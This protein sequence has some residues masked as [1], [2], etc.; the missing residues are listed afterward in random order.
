MM[1]DKITK[2][3][4]ELV[5]TVA[6]LRSPGGCPW[7][8]EQTHDSLKKYAIEETY[9]VIEAIESGDPK[10]IEDELGDLL[11][12]VLLHAQ[13]ASESEQFDI[14]DVCRVIRE[15]LQRRHPHVFADVEISGVE[16]VLYNWEQIKKGEPGYDQRKSVLDGVPKSLP[17]LMR[18]AEISKKAARTGFDWPDVDSIL[19]KLREETRELEEAINRGISKEIENEIGDLLFTTVNIAR[20][21]GIDP[22]EALRRM[23]EKFTRRFNHIEESAQRSGKSIQDMTLEEMDRVWD[24]AKNGE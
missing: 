9:E 14:G 16:D 21:K 23:L 3:F 15:K 4:E 6:I 8:K 10:K 20:F 5:R 17:A 7:D 19:D 11:L 24:E 22:E 12:Q 2:E 1:S 18:A 13:I